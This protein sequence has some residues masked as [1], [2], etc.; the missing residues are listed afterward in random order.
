MILLILI[1]Y[2]LNLKHAG[3]FF[4]HFCVPQ[5]LLFFCF[6]QQ[7]SHFHHFSD[8]KKHFRIFQ[9]ANTLF[10]GTNQSLIIASFCVQSPWK[11]S[12]SCH[13]MILAF[14]WSVFEISYQ[15]LVGMCFLCLKC[16]IIH[17]FPKAL[18]GHHLGCYFS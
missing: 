1:N 17:V 4:S 10:W 6:F 5:S 11:P 14:N 18:F 3:Q 7:K 8:F 15:I 2:P 16:K 9:K 12:V 13:L